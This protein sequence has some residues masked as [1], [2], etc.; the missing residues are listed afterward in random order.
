MKLQA[1][2]SVPHAAGKSSALC[3][4]KAGKHMLTSDYDSPKRH[5]RGESGTLGKPALG[6]MASPLSS[7]LL[8]YRGGRS[9]VEDGIAAECAE[10]IF[11]SCNSL[12]AFSSSSPSLSFICSLVFGLW[13]IGIDSAFE[14]V[15]SSGLLV[16]FYSS[17]RHSRLP[18]VW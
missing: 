17:E 9:G 11:A 1:R 15:Q 12:Q 10:R 14:P 18:F 4:P 8:L 7:L 2:D 16:G 13:S 3:P 5:K 6:E